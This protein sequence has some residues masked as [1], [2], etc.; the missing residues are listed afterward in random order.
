MPVAVTSIRRDTD[1]FGWTVVQTVARNVPQP[2]SAANSAPQATSRTSRAT[3]TPDRSP[4]ARFGRITAPLATRTSI[5]LPN[6]EQPA[7][8]GSSPRAPPPFPRPSALGTPLETTHTPYPR[9]VPRP[10][11]GLLCRRPVQATVP[12]QVAPRGDQAPRLARA[13]SHQRSRPPADKATLQSLGSRLTA[14]P[15]AR[16][17]PSGLCTARIARVN[18]RCY[19]ST[20]QRCVMEFRAP[21][22]PVEQRCSYTHAKGIFPP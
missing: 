12:A 4:S 16:R 9:G 3:F 11:H 19:A 21:P 18:A 20:R 13:E 7:L 10:A 14:A 22:S 17:C 8:V 15:Q 2:G 6:R 5:V 1:R